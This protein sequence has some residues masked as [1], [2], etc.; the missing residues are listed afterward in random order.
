M[1]SSLLPTQY[2]NGNMPDVV[3]GTGTI[4][5]ESSVNCRLQNKADGKILDRIVVAD[6]KSS[7][8]DSQGNPPLKIFCGIYTMEQSHTTN[9]KATRNTWAKKCDGFISFSTVEDPSF[10]V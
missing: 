10:P 8:V 7:S 5:D 2:L 9:A 6:I 3:D 1:D 4:A